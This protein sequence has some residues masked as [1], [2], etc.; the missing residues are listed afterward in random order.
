MARM[1]VG[2]TQAVPEPGHTTEAGCRAPAPDL[3]R[4]AVPSGSGP[5]RSASRRPNPR[6]ASFMIVPTRSRRVGSHKPHGADRLRGALCTSSANLDA[7]RAGSRLPKRARPRFRRSGSPGSP[8][9][10]L[11]H[12]EGRRAR[13]SPCLHQRPEAR[14]CS[15]A[16]TRAPLP[17]RP[18]AVCLAERQNG[19][20]VR[21]PASEALVVSRT[22]G[23]SAWRPAGAEAS[24]DCMTS[25]ASRITNAR[26]LRVACTCGGLAEDTSRCRAAGNA[27]STV[28]SARSTSA[29]A[30]PCRLQR[31]RVVGPKDS[32]LMVEELA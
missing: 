20:R 9:K 22:M 23:A 10:M 7:H 26:S 24:I 28:G 3:P 2:L 17:P 16:T 27:P 1:F 32:D 11:A 8:D 19:D 12:S 15:A 21:S 29:I 6:P 30:R 18:T 4:S 5:G 14:P 13:C 31:V 25:P